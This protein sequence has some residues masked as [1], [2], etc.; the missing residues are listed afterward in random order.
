MFNW[1][2]GAWRDYERGHVVVVT[3]VVVRARRSKHE[4]RARYTS[5]P[6]NYGACQLGCKILKAEK[7]EGK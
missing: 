4:R 7:S 1:V 6:D 2:L 5:I 3:V